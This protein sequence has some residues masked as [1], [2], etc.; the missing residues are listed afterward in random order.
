[1]KLRLFCVGKL[2]EP[3]LKAGASEYQERIGRYLPLTTSELREEKGGGKKPDARF[4]Q[5]Q[6]GARI[7]DRIPPGAFVIVLD[8]GGSPF[9]SEKVAGLLEHHMVQGT[10][11]LVMVIGGAYGLSA[12]VKKRA[13]LLLSLSA[14]TLTHQMARLFLLEQIYRGFT[15]VRNEPYH[16]R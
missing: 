14:L 7:L 9:T 13:D 12:G 3:W 15:I 6:E 1:M 5:E 11:E 16:N 10:A 2:S 8:E 4:I